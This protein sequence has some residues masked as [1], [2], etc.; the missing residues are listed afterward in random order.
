MNKLIARQFSLA[1]G[2]YYY[3]ARYY[4]ASTGRFLNEDPSE[5]SGND[6]NLYRYVN[7]SP[8]NWVDP[9]GLNAY[10]PSIPWPGLWP[11]VDSIPIPWPVVVGRVLGLV[12]GDLAFPKATSSDDV[13]RKDPLDCDK[14]ERC[15]KQLAADL[16][17]CEFMFEHDLP[18]LMACYE[19]ADENA[20]RCLN[21]LPRI[22]SDPRNKPEPNKPT[23]KKPDPPLPFPP[24]RKP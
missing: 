14:T 18:R 24:R 8:T 5:F 20:E 9:F 4:D 17:W 21:G 16:L 19:L 22:D 6:V 10:A 2:T 15:K 13:L 23:P 3:R 11:G 12:V 7:A 1:N